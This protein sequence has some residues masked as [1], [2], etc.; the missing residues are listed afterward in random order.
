MSAAIVGAR[1]T[2]TVGVIPDKSAIEL[3][4]EAARLALAGAGRSLMT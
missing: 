4:A 3:H 1:E 2:E